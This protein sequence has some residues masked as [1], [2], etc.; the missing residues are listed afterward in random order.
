MTLSSWDDPAKFQLTEET[1]DRPTYIKFLKVYMERNITI[2]KKYH[3]ELAEK[4]IRFL[5]EQTKELLARYQDRI[6]AQDQ[7]T[8]AYLNKQLASMDTSVAF[9]VTAQQELTLDKIAQIKHAME[10]QINL[11][12]IDNQARI[13]IAQ[14]KTH[15]N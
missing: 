5:P 3:K 13:D 12:R 4:P 14:Q 7:Y 2:L 6:R 11:E 8:L 15:G 9:R 1:G 10:D